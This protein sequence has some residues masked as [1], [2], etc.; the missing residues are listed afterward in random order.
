MFLVGL[1]GGISTG[2]STISKLFRD[3]G[4]P[5]ID[6]DI[7][8]RQVVEPGKKA[9]K[10][11][12]KEFGDGVFK[13]N[14]E[15]DRDALGKLI[16][17]DIEKRRKLNDITHPEIHCT[18]YKE[19]VRYFFLGHNFIVLDLPLLFETGVMLN[20]LHKI[21][22]VTC[23]EDIQLTRL[24]DR[25]KLSESDAKK[26]IASQMPLERKCEQSNFVI[27]NSG[28]TKDAEEQFYKILNILSESNQHWKIRGILLATTALL[29]S[30]IAWL[31]N[32]K[33]KFLGAASQT[34]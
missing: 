7:I 24:M 21:I 25:N 4:V 19:V 18:I 15:L 12:K 31:L 29:F 26:R 27:E 28:S 8:A 9:W 33:Y 23:E 1:T 34:S 6:A 14:G 11:I 22:T 17:D 20:Y 13:E 30:G 16:F 5:V 3:N 2:K 10:K 32:Y